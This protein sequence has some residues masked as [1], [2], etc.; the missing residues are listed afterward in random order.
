[1]DVDLDVSQAQE[2]SSSILKRKR[3]SRS[4]LPRRFVCRSEGCTKQYSRAEHLA[5]HQ[6]NRCSRDDVR[7]DS[8]EAIYRCES[9]DCLQTFVRHDLWLRHQHK[10]AEA[11][12][13]SAADEAEASG[14]QSGRPPHEAAPKSDSDVVKVRSEGSHASDAQP[15]SECTPYSVVT[16]PWP[17]HSRLPALPDPSFPADASKLLSSDKVDV[18]LVPPS[19]PAVVDWHAN[20]HTL[21]ASALDF[22]PGE[23]NFANWLLDSPGSQKTMHSLDLSGLPQFDFGMEFMTDYFWAFD[24]AGSQ[25]WS[26]TDTQE[27]L[28]GTFRHGQPSFGQDDGFSEA[29]R[30]QIAATLSAYWQR[31]RPPRIDGIIA[32]NSLL[33]DS[34]DGGW[35]NVTTSILHTCLS[36]FWTTVAKQLPIVHQPTFDCNDCKL[37][38]L[39]SMIALGAGQLVKN[40]PPGAMTDYRAFADLLV[41]NLRWDIFP[42]E[43]AQP[44]VQLWVA[45][46]LL[47]VEHY[48]KFYASRRLHERAHIHHASTITLL[49]RGSPMVGSGDESPEAEPTSRA[50]AGR[51][52]T[53]RRY[54]YGYD[55]HRW[56][57]QWIESESMRRVVFAAFQNDTLGEIL[58]G[59]QH[60]TAPWEIRL[61]LPC[62]EN[63]WQA[64]RPEDLHDLE[65]TIANVKPIKFLEGLKDVLHG[66]QVDTHYDGRMILVT[67][68][69]SVSCHIKRREKHLIIGTAPPP[70]EQE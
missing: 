49:R 6:L 37:L 16:L 36:A 21:A 24:N 43:D 9:S 53:G 29:R 64:K 31:R 5:R 38:L 23:D 27:G 40:S 41:L 30:G 20:Q 8:P 52:T 7:P 1:M 11:D 26:N 13:A 68:L 10:H 12:A 63:M 67:G 59:H 69:L 61:P 66:Q 70:R 2:S 18:G 39:L 28:E 33:F 14:R 22:M 50:G 45:Q 48:E 4:G 47:C 35:P 15:E 46:A 65:S 44:P 62:D 57:K 32:S 60:V 58:M 25:L 54:S 51:D 3:A 42:E 56:W 17:L 55:M 19:A 34:R